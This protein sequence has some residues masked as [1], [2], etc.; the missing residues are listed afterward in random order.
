MAGNSFGTCLTMTTFGES[1]GRALGVVIDGC[2]AGIALS[3]DA[4]QADLQRRRPGAQGD[5]VSPRQEADVCEILSGVFEGKT[6]GTP[7]TI[8]VRNID[9]RSADYERLKNIYRPGHADEAWQKKYGFRDWRGGGRASG[10]ETLARVAAGAVAKQILK[11]YNIAVNTRAIEIAGLCCNPPISSDDTMPPDIAAALHTI[12]ESGDSAGARVVCRIARV[13]AGL[14]EPV[15]DKLDAALAHAMLSI[16]GINGISFGAGFGVTAMH[17]SEVNA[18]DKNYGGGI[19]G[20]ISTG[21]DIV[22]TV[23][24]KPVPSIKK[25]QTVRSVAGTEM[26]FS[27]GGRSDTCLFPRIIPVIEAMALHVIADLLIQQT[28]MPH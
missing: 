22:F 25:T 19:S 18:L 6:L 26:R 17:G 3:E 24:V 5:Q 8:I 9:A 13:P 11:P 15:F 14:G 21:S 2:P 16:G 23:S 27:V 10:R 20:G 12:Q 4:I 28:G 7:I 1:H